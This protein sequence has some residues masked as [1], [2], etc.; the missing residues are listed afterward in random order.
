[1]VYI[2]TMKLIYVTFLSLLIAVNSFAV[3]LSMDGMYFPSK[4]SPKIGESIP[5]NIES[6]VYDTNYSRDRSDDTSSILKT[7]GYV[8]SISGLSA[9]F[10]ISIRGFARLDNEDYSKKSSYS[11]IGM[12]AGLMALGATGIVLLS[13]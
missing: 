2:P 7:F 12:G 10:I 1:M 13:W 8:L 11:T 6:Y 3:S 5:T 9:G 4:T